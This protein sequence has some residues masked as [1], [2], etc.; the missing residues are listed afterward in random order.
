ME[1]APMERFKRLDVFN[2][3]EISIFGGYI[4]LSDRLPALQ[5][6]VPPNLSGCP[7]PPLNIKFRPS[8]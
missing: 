3:S 7:K 4:L 2:S 6:P 5:L 8:I 1:M